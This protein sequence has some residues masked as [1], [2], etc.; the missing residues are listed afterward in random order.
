M[1]KSSTFFLFLT[2]CI[3]LTNAQVKLSNNFTI[4]GTVSNYSGTGVLYLSYYD[5]FNKMPVTDSSLVINNKFYFKGYITMPAIAFINKQKNN[6]SENSSLMVFIEPKNMGMRLDYTN[7]ANSKLSGS[8]SNNEYD[9]LERSKNSWYKILNTNSDTNTYSDNKKEAAYAKQKIIE[10]NEGFIR[11]NPGSFVALYQLDMLFNK[12]SADAIFKLYNNLEPNLQGHLIGL[13][14]KDKI[15]KKLNAIAGKEAFNFIGTD[16][17]G[18]ALKLSDYKGKY[19]LLDF[20]ASWCIP[21]RKE[22]PKLL[23][24]NAEYNNK[25]FEIIS[26]STDMDSVKWKAAVLNDKT[27]VWKNMRSDK[28]YNDIASKFAVA[29]LPTKFLIDTTGIIIKRFESS[30]ETSL[31]YVERFLKSKFTSPAT[32]PSSAV[33]RT[34]TLRSGCP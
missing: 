26:I 31:E 15:L 29:V 23:E 1:K 8:L 30:D 4:N 16:M 6:F 27:C 28:F 5:D 24:M 19:I 34:G 25:N 12:I 18:N 2:L 32:S 9:I 7:V 10:I 3:S 20:W 13:G 21:C 33:G 14:L 17:E 11:R 22:M